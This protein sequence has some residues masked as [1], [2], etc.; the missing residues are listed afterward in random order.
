MFS[1]YTFVI[2]LPLIGFGIHKINQ[3]EVDPTDFTCHHQKQIK[4]DPG[5]LFEFLT[6][7]HALEKV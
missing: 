4:G 6:S 3:F 2:I 1:K 5:S 7:P